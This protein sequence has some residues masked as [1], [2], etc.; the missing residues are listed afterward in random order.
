MTHQ[1]PDCGLTCHCGGDIDDLLLD[2][3]KYVNGCTHCAGDDSEP[4][5]YDYDDSEYCA[6]CGAP[7]DGGHRC[8]SCGNG[9]PLATGE[10]DSVSG[11]QW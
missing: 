6:H 2:L 3:D 5:F 8:G 11:E 4:D 1:C 9:D 7:Y 10:F